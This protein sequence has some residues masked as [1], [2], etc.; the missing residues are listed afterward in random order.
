MN[1]EPIVPVPFPK[2]VN[3]IIP[4]GTECPYYA[5]KCSKSGVNCHHNGVDHGADYECGYCKAFRMIDIMN[6]QREELKQQSTPG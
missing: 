5:E 2:D 3:G 4:K 1:S 6:I